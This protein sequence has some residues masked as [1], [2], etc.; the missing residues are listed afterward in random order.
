MIIKEIKVYEPRNYNHLIFLLGFCVLILPNFLLS[1]YQKEI[2]KIEYEIEHGTLKKAEQHL[3]RL[4]KNYKESPQKD[5]H[6]TKL[7]L[8]I[9][10]FDQDFFPYLTYANQLVSIAR[11]LKPIYQAEAFAYKSYYWHFMMWP[12]SALYYSNLSFNL[13]QKNRVNLKEI[14]PAFVYE[15]YAITYLY[16]VDDVKISAYKN[17]DLDEY[18]RKQFLYF[19]SCEWVQ[20][21]YPFKF[22]SERAMFYRSYGNRLLDLVSSYRICSKDETKSFTKKQWYGTKRA[23]ELYNKGLRCIKPYHKNDF[24]ALTA[25]KAFNYTLIGEWAI[26]AKIYN[27][28][29]KIISVHG[30]MDRRYVSYMPL[31]IFI[32]FKIKNDILVPYNAR[33]VKREI[34]ML[35]QLKKEFWQRLKIACDM[36]YDPYRLS[37]YNDVFT[38]HHFQSLNEKNKKQLTYYAVSNLLTMKAYFHFIAT[39][40]DK[41][42]GELPYFSVRKIQQ[43]LKDNE[44][45]LLYPNDADYLSNQ[46]ILITNKKIH[47][48]NVGHKSNLSI[49]GLDTL[50]FDGFKKQSFEGFQNNFKDVLNKEPLLTKIYICYDDTNPYEIF[51]RNQKGKNYSELDFLGKGINFVRIYNPVT[52]F[53]KPMNTTYSQMDVRYLEQK[54][55]SKLLFTQDYFKRQKQLNAFSFQKYNGDVKN[56]LQQRGIL[57]LFGHGNLNLDQA[58]NVRSF[59]WEFLKNLKN[60]EATFN[61]GI[62]DNL[63]ISRDLVVLNQCYSGYPNFN[64]NEFNKNISLHILNKGSK[65]VITSPNVVDDYYSSV[66]FKLFY[67]RILNNE[68]FEEAFYH[69]R[70]DFFTNHPEMTNPRNLMGLQLMVSYSVNYEENKSRWV[71]LFALVL[72]AIDLLLTVLSAW[73]R[74][75]Q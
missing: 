73:M 61:K 38:L 42:E 52:F 25:L 43:S 60:D 2:S 17:L 37:P 16:R 39:L 74:K 49:D 69:A 41:K 45:Y 65:T 18:Q 44:A 58:S 7:L 22:T 66:F 23:N 46:K 35:N 59:Q 6:S 36:P 13:F 54:N 5:Y 33:T 48:V 26:S 64:L 47:F 34:R 75:R 9:K 72:I 24:L 71:I 21:K 31:K 3:V 68:L 50:N 56:L 29:F 55:V 8:K 40:R 51:I 12:D 28:V 67:R 53:T 15:I 4:K 20:K 10:C 63:A 19:D 14:D 11:K 1:Q 57:H 32:S 70:N 27:S 62:N 30:L